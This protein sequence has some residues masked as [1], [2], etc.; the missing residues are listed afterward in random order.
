MSHFIINLVLIYQKTFLTVSKTLVARPVNRFRR[1]DSASCSSAAAGP[2]TLH[3]HSSSGA[4]ETDH[5]GES[6]DG[7][8]EAGR[9]TVVTPKVKWYTFWKKGTKQ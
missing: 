6:G 3:H 8:D 1:T 7:E 4:L 9:V 2:S 5:Q